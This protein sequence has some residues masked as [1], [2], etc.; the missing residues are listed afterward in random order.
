M[1][2]HLQSCDYVDPDVW[3]HASEALL[4]WQQDSG[5]NKENIPL[6]SSAP[7]TNSLSSLS[8]ITPCMDTDESMTSSIPF[9]VLHPPKHY[10]TGG[11]WDPMVQRVFNEDF[12]TMLIATGAPWNYANNSVLHTFY[13]K[14]VP[15]AIVPD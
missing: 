13:E 4:Y 8:D 10:K 2:L 15:G 1:L 6:T 11:K 12:C 14:W 3:K 7:R 5:G 9:Y